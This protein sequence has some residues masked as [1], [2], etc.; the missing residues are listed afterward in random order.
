M[1]AEMM[2][3]KD[4]AAYLNLNEKKIYALIKQGHIPCTK[5]TGKWVFPRGMVDRWIVK[6]GSGVSQGDSEE[7]LLPWIWWR[8]A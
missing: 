7:R 5:V 6:C 4:V 2:S 3:T 1:S 8:M